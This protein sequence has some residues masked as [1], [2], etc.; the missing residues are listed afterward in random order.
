M[1]EKLKWLLALSFLPALALAVTR[2]FELTDALAGYRLQVLCAVRSELYDVPRLFVHCPADA[3]LPW[4]S[5]L[6]LAALVL[7]VVPVI[8]FQIA[9]RHCGTD[10]ARNV[11]LFPRLVPWAMVVT[12]I[13]TFLQGLLITA[14]VSLFAVWATLSWVV[15]AAIMLLAVI[16]S[17]A[18]VIASLRALTET[19]V[20]GEDAIAVGRAD[21]PALW[22][23]IDR[24][25]WR[26]GSGVPQT[27]LIGLEGTFWVASRVVHTPGEDAPEVHVGRILYLSLPIMHRLERDELGTIIAHELAHFRAGD[28]AYTTRLAPTYW[29]LEQAETA[30]DDMEMPFEHIPHIGPIFGWLFRAP[31]GLFLSLL[32][33]S[34]HANMTAIGRA[35]EFSAD[36]GALEISTPEIAARTLVRTVLYSRRLSALQWSM[37]QRARNGQEVTQRFAETFDALE[38]VDIN[39]EVDAITADMEHEIVHPFDT[40]PPTAARLRALGVD[41]ARIDLRAALDRPSSPA[42]AMLPPFLRERLDARLSEWERWHIGEAIAYELQPT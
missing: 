40:H 26:L 19:P 17:T 33:H 38:P 6:A 21:A 23:M 3:V 24:I 29:A 12:A 16:I 7:A 30:F 25:G 35:R 27:V 15:V 5:A 22:R 32:V 2:A 41:P 8:A 42:V 14:L 31:T 11:Q 4:I 1:V 34:F 39:G 9:A 37:L 28:V 13:T 18:A 20:V 36:R 10:P